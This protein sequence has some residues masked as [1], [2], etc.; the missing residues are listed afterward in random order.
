MRIKELLLLVSGILFLFL[1][2]VIANNKV[3]M[4]YHIF[5]YNHIKKHHLQHSYSLKPEEARQVLAHLIG[6][7]KF[8]K[9]GFQGQAT[10]VID[11]IEIENPFGLWEEKK[12]HMLITLAGVINTKTFFTRNPLFI[13]ENSPSSQAYNYLI[14]RF[15]NQYHEL[16]GLP[17]EHLYA[18]IYGGGLFLMP[19]IMGIHDHIQHSPSLELFE[20]KFGK[21]FSGIFNLQHKEDRCFLSEILS[22]NDLIDSLSKDFHVFPRKLITAH[23]TSLEILYHHYGA[24]S[25]QY[26]YASKASSLVINNISKKLSNTTL[27]IILLSPT[28]I[29]KDPILR[30]AE[31]E[32]VFGNDHSA[33]AVEELKVVSPNCYDSKANC[34]KITNYCS[35]HGSC[36]KYLG[37]EKCYTCRCFPTITNVTGK[38]R[39]VSYWS[40]DLCQKKDIS[41]EFQMF[42][43]TILL[44]LIAL[45]WTI[46]LLYNIGNEE[47]GAILMN[48]D[49]YKKP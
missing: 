6:V 11:S 27:T 26:I 4:V 42:F 44:F 15:L 3:G 5:P 17:I 49:V 33:P 25:S 29:I 19:P 22:L 12:N 37:Q 8:H 1:S 47:L 9:F 20:S 10:K 16:T 18:N 43:W 13:I 31:V 28:T 36:E 45:I 2:D 35:N 7:S 46:M 48:M 24:N 41:S 14:R 40:G 23:L 34:E 21:E 30:R 39:K 32:N 38:G